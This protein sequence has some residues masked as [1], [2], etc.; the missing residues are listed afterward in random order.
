MKRR[1]RR[2]IFLTGLYLLAVTTSAS[3]ECAWV[4]WS[5][6]SDGRSWRVELAR[7]T[8]R[9]CIKDLDDRAKPIGDPKLD[10]GQMRHRMAP[11]GSLHLWDS[12]NDRKIMFT[13]LPDT[14]DPRGPKGGVR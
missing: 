7:P 8:V 5:S 14:V 3:A 12:R 1:A 6:Q 4:L 11:T 10:E 9:D 2:I 13:C